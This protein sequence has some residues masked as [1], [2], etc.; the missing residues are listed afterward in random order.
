MRPLPGFSEVEAQYPQDNG[1]ACGFSWASSGFDEVAA[2]CH[3]TLISWR[4]VLVFP[5][6][7]NGAA[8]F[9]RR[10]LS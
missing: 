3:R 9:R 10:S 8:A 6:N 1:W 2:L 7:F 4:I 5:A